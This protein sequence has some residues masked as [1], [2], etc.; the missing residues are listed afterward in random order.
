MPEGIAMTSS[1]FGF[2]RERVNAIHWK[3]FAAPTDLAGVSG[4]PE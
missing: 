2:G 3:D 4:H 1:K